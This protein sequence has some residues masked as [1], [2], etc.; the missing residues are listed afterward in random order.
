CRILRC[1]KK[2]KPTKLPKLCEVCINSWKL[3]CPGFE[4][5]ILNL[6][7][8][9][10]HINRTIPKEFDKLT[11]QKK[12][13]WIRC[14]L[15][16]ENGG[17]WMDASILLTQNITNWFKYEYDFIAVRDGK[18]IEN[19]FFA[20]TKKS[21]L[22]LEWIREYEYAMSIGAKKYEEDTMKLVEWKEWTY[23]YHQL[24][25][26]RA[27]QKLSI[28]IFDAKNPNHYILNIRVI[29]YP[30]ADTKFNFKNDWANE[31]KHNA[32]RLGMKS[33]NIIALY[34]LP[35]FIRKWAK[36]A[37]QSKIQIG[38]PLDLAGY[39]NKRNSLNKIHYSTIRI[40]CYTFLK[41]IYKKTY[42]LLSSNFSAK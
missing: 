2:G 20:A 22:L 40:Y 36:K 9:Q 37:L 27:C 1:P 31:Y 18:R 28:N 29:G 33:N 41:T 35:N 6:N 14:V 38:S 21:P 30:K 19:W 4:I 10:N 24:C 11:I 25:F 42:F 32:V 8:F 15:I 26:L 23:L 17:I 34:K 3:H 39:S 7:N 5:F 16:Y 12:T 13:N